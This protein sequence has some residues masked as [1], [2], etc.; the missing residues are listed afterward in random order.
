METKVNFS[1]NLYFLLNTYG[2]QV[3]SSELIGT[4]ESKYN[5]NYVEKVGQNGR[6]HVAQEIKY[7][8]FGD[9]KLKVD[10]KIY[11]SIKKRMPNL[12]DIFMYTFVCVCVCVCLQVCCGILQY[13]STQ[14]TLSH[15]YFGWQLQEIA[16]QHG[17]CM[18]ARI[19]LWIKVV[20]YNTNDLAPI[21][22]QL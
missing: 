1:W 2:Y 16:R 22:R 20:C 17:V 5:E 12:I 15:E 4:K 3:F 14:L 19:Q 21:R 7:L 10:R 6:P 8:S 11:Q 13:F 18:Y 9:G